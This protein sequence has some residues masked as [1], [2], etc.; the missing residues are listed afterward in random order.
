[1]NG[2]TICAGLSHAMV[3]EASSTQVNSVVGVLNPASGVTLSSVDP[4][5]EIT[6]SNEVIL[7]NVIL[8]E[9]VGNDRGKK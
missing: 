4:F 1:M 5:F 2:T 8:R 6:G 3:I 9:Q 7:K